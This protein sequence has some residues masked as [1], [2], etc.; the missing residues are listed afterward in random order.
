[1]ALK[2]GLFENKIRNTCKVLKGGGE[3]K[4]ERSFEK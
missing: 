1:M 3:E 4:F 2:R